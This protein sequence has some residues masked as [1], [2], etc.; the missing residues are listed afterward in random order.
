M[1]IFGFII[2]C[3]VVSAC[4]DLKVYSD[5]DKETDFDSFDSFILLPWTQGDSLINKFDKER[6][7]NSV[8]NQMVDRGHAYYEDN[9]KLTVSLFLKLDNSRSTTTYSNYYGGYGYGYPGWG[10]GGGMSSSI[11]SDNYYTIG[12]LVIDVYDTKSKQLIWQGVGAKSVDDIP[13]SREKS[14]PKVISYIF[15]KYPRS[16]QKY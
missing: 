2:T 16:I 8:K 3:L 11:Y 10:W 14:V 1:K 5:Y 13:Q 12:T 9:A 7:M 15:R 6:I 4:S